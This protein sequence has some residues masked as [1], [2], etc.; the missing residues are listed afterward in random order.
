M[1]KH[2]PPAWADKFLEWYCRPD[3][4]ETI[5]GD[6]HELFYRNA[7]SSR[8]KANAGFVWNVLR[9]LRWKNIRKSKSHPL[10]RFDMLQH[11][12]KLGFRN[13]FR[14]KN[15]SIINIAGLAVAIGAVLLIGLYLQFELTYDEKHERHNNIYRV[16]TTLSDGSGGGLAKIS[17]PV[18]PAATT[19]ARNVETAARVAFTPSMMM[20]VGE[21]KAYEN[22]GFYADPSVFDV[23]SLKVIEGNPRTMLSQVNSIVLTPQLVKKYFGNEPALGKMITLN[24]NTSAQVSGV[25]D[26]L[27]EN[28]HFQYSFLMPMEADIRGWKEVW[29]R[30]QYYTYLLTEDNADL[31]GIQQDLTALFVKNVPAEQINFNIELQPLTSIHLHSDL[32]REMSTNSTMKSVYIFM[33][34]ALLV[35]VIACINYINIFTAKATE[36]LKEIGMRK[37]AGAKRG[38]LIRQFLSE[39]FLMTALA[40]IV[41][42]GLCALALPYFSF[43]IATPLHLTGLLEPTFLGFFLLLLTSVALLAGAYPSFYLSAIKALVLQRGISVGSRSRWREALVIVQFTISAFMIAALMGVTGQTSYMENKFLG[44]NKSNVI[45]FPVRDQKTLRAKSAVIEKLKSNPHILD[46]SITGTTLGGNDW[47]VPVV[48]EAVE[49]E[50]QPNTR[51]LVVDENFVPTYQLKIQSGRNFSVEF[52]ADSSNAVLVNARAARDF[53]WGDNVIGRT[54][55]IPAAGKKAQVVGVVEDFHFRS[56]HEEISPVVFFMQPSWFQNVSI[57]LDGV[58]NAETVEYIADV[59]QELE[60]AFP[61]SYSWFDQSLDRLYAADQNTN[62]LVTWFGVLAVVLACIGLFSLTAYQAARRSREFGIR[63]VL[64]ASVENILGIQLR[65]YALVAG[66]GSLMACTIAWYVIEQWLTG[67]AYRTNI[68]FSWFVISIVA[69]IFVALATSMYQSLRSAM[70][71]PVESIKSNQ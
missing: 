12:F 61:F 58:Q 26:A 49:R 11:Y 54:I 64:G 31:A 66:F 56:L 4:L 47:G 62:R 19:N 55:E 57:R 50:R 5:Q 37:V 63:K 18:G 34:V 44:F 17:G 25:I 28:T 69:S 65:S 46:V 29:D 9:F 3:M 14:N 2:H 38:E 41:G 40:A 27:Q 6:V 48:P 71:N 15:H 33:S 24:N 16:V 21:V 20:E 7:S 51:V 52:P 59:W 42:V 30:P 10:K 68:Q 67:F 32:L 23:F 45:I 13:L 43:A 35:L 1:S 8:F 53:G 36:R 60:P 22:G 70:V 39:S